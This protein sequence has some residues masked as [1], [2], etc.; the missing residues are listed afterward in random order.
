LSKPSLQRLK[1]PPKEKSKK[2]ISLRTLMPLQ[3]NSPEPPPGS[4]LSTE[5]E[6]PDKTLLRRESKEP[7]PPSMA[8]MQ[9][10]PKLKSLWK[11]KKPPQSMLQLMVVLKPSLPMQVQAVFKLTLRSNQPLSE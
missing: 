10:K 11:R 2:M 8:T 1:A 7:Q 3:R 4:A 6:K 9:K 5:A